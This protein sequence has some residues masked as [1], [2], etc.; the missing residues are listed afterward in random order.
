MPKEKSA[1]QIELEVLKYKDWE[2]WAERPFGAF[3]MSLFREG[4]KREYIRKFGVDAEWPVLL[5][6]KGTF[7]KSETVWNIFAK[8]LEKYLAKGGTVFSITKSCERFLVNNKKFVRDLN[9]SKLPPQKKLQ[10]LYEPLTL[11]MSYIWLTHGFEHVYKKRLYKEVPK[12]IKGDID[13]YIGDISFPIKKNAHH[14]LEEAL[15]SKQPLEQIRERWGWIKARDGFSDIFTIKELALERKKLKG[16]KHSTFKK[17]RV[18]KALQSLAKVSQELVYLRT[19]RTD[20]LYELMYLARPTLNEVAKLYKIPFKSL[21]DYAVW[22]LVQGKLKKYL[23]TPDLSAI[24]VGKDFV[25]LD[26]PILKDRYGKMDSIK[27]LIANKGFAV[28]RAKIVKIAHEIGKVKKG[29][30]LFAPTTF[31]SFIMGMKRA[32][33][34]VT[35][36]G[37]ITSHAAIT[38]REMKK[39]CVIGTQIGTKVFKDGDLIEVDA[40]NGIV[41]KVK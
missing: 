31:P 3:V 40:N 1:K 41:R 8:Q 10:K 19:L 27:G 36:E 9:K 35:D 14:H 12:Y 16:T 7:Y 23:Y 34:F 20:V 33:A 39:P 26:H 30:I 17:I 32:A 29:D 4:Q 6:Q 21:R 13:K 24:S 2:W 18:P 38:A 22:D 15:R 25:L 5:F 28:G 11:I 37:G